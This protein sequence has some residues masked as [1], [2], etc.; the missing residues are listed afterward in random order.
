M[1]EWLEDFMSSKQGEC[2][3]DDDKGGALPPLCHVPQITLGAPSGGRVMLTWIYCGERL[4]CP[5]FFC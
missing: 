2:N 1:G 3:S 5:Q 4:N